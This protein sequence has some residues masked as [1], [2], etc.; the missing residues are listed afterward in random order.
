MFPLDFEEFLWATGDSTTM[1]VIR[2]SF[3]KKLPLGEAYHRNVMVMFRTYM[4]V[5]G[6]PQSVL[7][8]IDTNNLADVEKVK[9][10]ILGLY[11]KDIARFSDGNE[12]KIRRIFDKIPSQLAKKEKKFMLSALGTN[13]RLRDFGEA[14]FWLYDSMIVNACV[15]VSDPSYGLTMNEDD[16]RV[17]CYMGDTG[18]LVTQSMGLDTNEDPDLHRMILFDKIG[19]NEGMFMENIVAQAFR[20]QG[21]RLFFYSRSGSETKDRIGIDFLI[22]R[23][24]KVCPVEVKSSSFAKHASLDKYLRRFGE[25]AGQPY[26]LYQ[27][28]LMVRDG[29]I[30]LPLYMAMLL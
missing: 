26:I 27:N 22:R 19:L 1:D 21:R 16:R 2:D 23:E 28:D 24:G 18:L 15:N 17:K 11:R 30:H 14:F 13:A 12:S 8:F 9:A 6:M 7:K 29:I 25:R 5:G 3:D 4:M 10:N 20:S